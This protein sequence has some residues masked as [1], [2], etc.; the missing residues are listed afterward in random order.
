VAADVRPAAADDD[1]LD[2]PAAAR[3]R[4]AL[5]AVHEKAVLEAAA[6]AVEVAE[7]VNRRPLRVDPGG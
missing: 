5:A 2:H 6:G 1:L 7:V 3:A 4:L